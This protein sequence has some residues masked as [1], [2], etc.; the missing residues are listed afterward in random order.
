MSLYANPL[1][2]L[3]FPYLLRLG[4]APG[5]SQHPRPPGWPAARPPRWSW[6]PPCCPPGPSRSA[7]C[8]CPRRRWRAPVGC[9]RM[10]R[11]PALVYPRAR[12]AF[13][14]LGPRPSSRIPRPRQPPPPP[15]A[16]AAAR[17]APL[18]PSA[19]LPIF[20]MSIFNFHVVKFWAVVDGEGGR[21]TAGPRFRQRLRGAR[22]QKRD[23]GAGGAGAGARRPP[24]PGSRQPLGRVG[25]VTAD[26]RPAGLKEI[27]SFLWRSL[28]NRRGECLPGGPGVPTYLPGGR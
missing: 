28:C 14:S 21:R 9:P 24:G 7:P 17:P 11:L 2:I 19:S 15:P 5:T 16:A 10:W 26:G 18:L 22:P 4:S 1:R 6:R 3:R 8:G 12:P 27:F 20:P 25:S 23:R 13:S